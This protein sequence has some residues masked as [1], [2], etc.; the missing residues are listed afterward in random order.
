MQR[1]RLYQFSKGIGFPDG[2]GA[3]KK[4]RS[5]FKKKLIVDI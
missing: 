5:N 1:R 3:E 2:L 4:I